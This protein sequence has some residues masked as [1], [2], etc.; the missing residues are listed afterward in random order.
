M[1]LGRWIKT[2]KNKIR[3]DKIRP[4]ASC[5]DMDYACPQAMVSL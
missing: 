2:T 4:Q 1:Q 5:G 3:G